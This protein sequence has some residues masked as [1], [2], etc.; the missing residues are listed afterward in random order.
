MPRIPH[1]ERLSRFND[2][3]LEL[4]LNLRPL[5][6][7]GKSGLR[8]SVQLPASCQFVIERNKMHLVFRNVTLRENRVNRTFK[9]WPFAVS[10]VTKVRP[11]MER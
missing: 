7:S 4:I 3:K 6:G 2:K 11:V 9:V 1:H 8:I 5:I 10:C